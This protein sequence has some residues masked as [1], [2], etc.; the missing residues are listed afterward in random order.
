[1]SEENA[2][3]LRRGVEAFNDGDLD[4]LVADFAPEFEYVTTGRLTG[5]GVTYRGPAEYL[6]FLEDMFLSEFSEMRLEATDFIDADDQVLVTFTV[7]GRGKQSGAETSWTGFLVWTLRDGTI[8]RGQAFENR[9]EA[10]EA[11]ELSE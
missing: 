8:T 9:A 3:I 1:M 7:S 2:E 11:A 5:A 10:L 6:R 4:A